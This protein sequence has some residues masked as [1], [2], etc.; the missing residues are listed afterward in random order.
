MTG[1]NKKKNDNFS[2]TALSSAMTEHLFTKFTVINNIAQ[3]IL[4][5][6][7]TDQY[8]CKR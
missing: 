2:C 7:W 6:H 3:H 8:N 4:Q 5:W 1:I